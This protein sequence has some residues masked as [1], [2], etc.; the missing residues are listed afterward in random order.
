MIPFHTIAIDFI[1]GL[2]ESLS[3]N[4]ML[5][6]VTDKFTKR[7]AFLARQDIY[8]VEDW[9][10]KLINHLQKADW[11][12]LQAIISDRDPKFMSEFWKTVFKK[13][14]ISILTVMAYYPQ[15]DR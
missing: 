13:L 2:P 11:G 3:S 5:L 1:V 10:D 7:V 8:T 15:T 12:M 9:A 6:S 4:N 14:G